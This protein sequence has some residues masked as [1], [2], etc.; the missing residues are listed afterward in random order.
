MPF[1]TKEEK[2]AYDRTRYAKP[3]VKARVIAQR[4]EYYQKNKAK[5]LERVRHWTLLRL[6]KHRRIVDEAKSKPCMDCRLTYPLCVMDFDHR[7]DERKGGSI[8]DLVNNWK[9]SERVLRE[10]IAKCDV[11]CSNCHRIRTHE[12][13]QAGKNVPG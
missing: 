3:H 5:V 10:E 1:K 13:R 6:A 8:S 4:K 7:P 11:V 12:R 9:I 2:R